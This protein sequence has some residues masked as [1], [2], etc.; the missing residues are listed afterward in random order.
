MSLSS[1]LRHCPKVDDRVDPGS[2]HESRANDT[3]GYSGQILPAELYLVYIEYVSRCSVE[4]THVSLLGIH[5][6]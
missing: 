5:L 6:A 3:S 2:K 4:T 1:H